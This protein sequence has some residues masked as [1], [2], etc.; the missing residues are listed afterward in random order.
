MEVNL[1]SEAMKFMVLGMGVVFSFL[2][3]LVFVLKF[4]AKLIA[5]YFP[6][7]EVPACDIAK[8]PATQP[9]AKQEDNSGIIAAIT[10]AVMHHRK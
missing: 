7:A 2:T 10:A 3:F 9:A 6:D 8:T 5:K 1:V 4:Q